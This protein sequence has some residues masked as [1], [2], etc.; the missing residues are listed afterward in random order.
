[1][2]EF[3]PEK[4]NELKNDAEEFYN[5][6]GSVY[7]PYFKEKINFN[8]KGW[9]H[10]IFKTWNRTRPI[11]DQ[12]SRLRHIKLA[13][14]VIKES[15]TLQGHWSTQKFERTKKKENGWEQTLKMTNYYEFIA[16]MESH[17]SKVRV[18]VIVKQ[19]DGGEKFFLSIIPF[20]GRNKKGDRVMHSGDPEND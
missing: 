11:A 8:V 17:G 13:S 4:F 12:Y 6:I 7:C 9:D 15:K 2:M 16:V 14:E 10:L 19:I 20:W 3:T 5:K 18:K 1:M